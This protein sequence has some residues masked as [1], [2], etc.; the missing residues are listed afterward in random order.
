MTA[1]KL[2]DLLAGIANVEQPVVI[3]GLTTD[4]RQVQT[5]DVF[6]A[7][8][9]YQADGRDYID[10]ALA[11]G[12]AAI[13]YD[14]EQG[15]SPQQADKNIPFIAVKNLLSHLGDI[16]A[17]FYEHPSQALLTVGITGTNGKTSCAK[18]I[19]EGLTKYHQRCAVL[20][21]LGNGFLPDLKA[22]THTTLDPISL[23]AQLAEFVAQGAK[24]VAMEVSSHALVQERVNGVNFDIAVFTQ[25]SRDHLDY[26][27][28]MQS[29]AQAKEKL[30]QQPGLRYGIINIDDALGEMLSEK[31]EKSLQ[32]VTYSASG[33]QTKHGHSIFATDIRPLD[34]G[35]EVAVKT[36]HGAGSFKTSLLGRF[37]I[38]NLLA[39]LG[40]LLA[41][42]VPFKSALSIL[43]TLGTVKGR[44]ETFGGGNKP[45]VVV[46]YAHT[47]DA[48]Q[49]ALQALRE[50]C[51]G[52]LWCVFGCGGDRDQGKRPLMAAVA[53]QFADKMIITN[54]NPRTESPESIVQDM[55]S[56]LQTPQ[57]AAVIYDRAFA[58][59]EAVQSAAV[60]DIVLVAGK[61]HEAVQIIGNE[62]I[63]FDDREQVAGVLAKIK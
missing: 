43:S 17:R 7:Y 13:V 26:H 58:I 56:G 34:V 59:Q 30:F 46:D 27:G 44:M 63:P 35:F 11:A 54:D 15:W 52:Q 57:A 37:N 55:L 21:T 16:A 51:D 25:L 47:P 40:V 31:Y 60:N 33:C 62:Q 23:Q 29:Y 50:H 1:K 19:A 22:S 4:S 3:T 53:E 12:A 24:A 61:G 32:V 6:F 2:Q 28:D 42:E 45:Q 10:K 38:S 5:G 48:L 36:P 18:L 49:K 9:G 20:G 14:N 39:S 8:K 41:A